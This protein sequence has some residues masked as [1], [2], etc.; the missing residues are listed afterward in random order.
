MD[1]ANEFTGC[2]LSLLCT[3]IKRNPAE[4]VDYRMTLICCYGAPIRNERQWQDCCRLC[5]FFRDRVALMTLCRLWLGP[6]WSTACR[7]DPLCTDIKPYEIDSVQW[8]LKLQSY[9]EKRTP[10]SCKV[11]LEEH[12]LSRMLLAH[13]P[14]VERWMGPGPPGDR[15]LMQRLC[16]GQLCVLITNSPP[17]FNLKQIL[18]A[19]FS[20]LTYL[21]SGES[22]IDSY[23][24]YL[25]EM[26]Y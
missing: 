5:T 1:N 2:C 10:S 23:L 12:V 22:A 24:K 25:Q 14:A 8:N 11:G 13:L 19:S 17:K 21:I 18:F 20:S 6:C 7:S 9:Q 15:V 16:I 4:L 26:G 3:E